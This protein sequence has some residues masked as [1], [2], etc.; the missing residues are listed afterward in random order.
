MLYSLCKKQGEYIFMENLIDTIKHNTFVVV[1]LETTG[2]N[3]S[4]EYGNVDYIIEIGNE[5]Y[6]E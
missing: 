5:K 1:D 2:L 4:M 3:H 6:K